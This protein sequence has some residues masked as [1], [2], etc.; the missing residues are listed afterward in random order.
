MKRV[1]DLQFGGLVLVQ[2][3]ALPRFSEDSVLLA[4]FLRL[5]P[6]DRAVDLGSGTGLLSVLGQGKTGAAFVGV[7]R[8]A[9]LC[10]L[11]RE[12]AARNGQDIPF[13]E[14]DV[15][16]APDFFGHGSFTA[17]VCNPPYFTAGGPS[18]DGSRAMARHGQADTLSVFLRVAF[19]LLK[20]GGA[21]YLCYPAPALAA[22]F[23]ALSDARLAPKRLRLVSNG[24]EKAPRL[25]L[26]QAKKNAKQ[27]LIV[28]PVQFLT[29]G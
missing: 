6:G 7:E 10:A 21:L 28:E 5:G 24:V 8:Q 9:A 25:A 20:N 26:V 17:A 2:D 18:A 19:L 13:Y 4:N 12:S 23:C 27:G 16:D 14:M 1:D 11:S 29:Q 22:L 3:T 15:A